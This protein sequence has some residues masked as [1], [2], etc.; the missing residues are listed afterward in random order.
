MIGFTYTLYIELN[1]STQKKKK[2]QLTKTKNDLK[3]YDLHVHNS[4]RCIYA[5]LSASNLQLIKISPNGFAFVSSVFEFLLC[6]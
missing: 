1:I 3:N 5:T 4:P 6:F 2:K